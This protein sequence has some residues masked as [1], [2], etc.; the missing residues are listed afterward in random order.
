MV[1]HLRLEQLLGHQKRQPEHHIAHFRHVRPPPLRLRAHALHATACAPT[2]L[3]LRY[4]SQLWNGDDTSAKALAI[5][6]LLVTTFINCLGVSTAAK[7]QNAFTGLKVPPFLIVASFPVFYM[8]ACRCL[9]W[10]SS[11][12]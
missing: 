9:A 5:V 7:L 8:F 6:C 3:V 10:P 11:S 1:V 12:L 2:V 4:A